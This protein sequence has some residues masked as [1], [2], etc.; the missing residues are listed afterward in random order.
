ML[1]LLATKTLVNLSFELLE[2]ILAR[3]KQFSAALKFARRYDPSE[4]LELGR[5]HLGMN[6]LLH[7]V[8]YKESL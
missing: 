7:E 3:V 2:H 8:V 6:D 1:L 4:D 5:N